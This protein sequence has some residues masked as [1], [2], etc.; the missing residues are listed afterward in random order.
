MGRGGVV[1][2]L[3]PGLVLSERYRLIGHVASGGMGQVWEAFDDV[4]ERRLALKIMHPHTQ[5]EL[6]LV[7]RFRDEAR[8][9]A[10]LT[11]PNIVTI[12]DYLEEDGLSCLVMEFVDG[13]TLCRMLS[14]GPLS[15][16]ITRTILFELAS[17]LTVAHEAGVIH[18]D[19][20]PANVLVPE[21]GAKLTDF[22]IARSIDR[23]SRTLTGQVLG[24]AHYLSPEQALGQQVGPASD[25]YGLGVLA[26]EMLTG[27][28]PFDRTSPIATAL[29]HVQDPPPPLPEGTPPDLESLITA[30]MAKE[31]EERPTAALVA[32]LLE[33]ETVPVASEEEFDPDATAALPAIPRRAATI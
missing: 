13:P 29:A 3:R 23:D 24:T 33:P 14:D 30:C 16:E 2:R 12:H 15:P 10:Q 5:E 7:E 25:I 8:F 20:K 26:H 1:Q 32:K 19:I 6:A 4:L 22:G 27:K 9:A 11:H 28:K 17:A 18:R 21:T 31:P